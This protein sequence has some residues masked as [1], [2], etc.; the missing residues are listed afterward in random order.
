M[1]LLDIA[2]DTY[3][4][5]CLERADKG[6]MGG[7]DLCDLIALVLRNTVIAYDSED[8]R[9]VGAILLL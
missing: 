8:F 5:L 4:R 2:L 1:L 7:D 3:F 6:A 9:Q